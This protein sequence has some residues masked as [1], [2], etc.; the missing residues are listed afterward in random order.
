[1]RVVLNVGLE[2]DSSLQ[3]VISTS[4]VSSSKTIFNFSC[5]KI[6]E[7][8][9][10][11]NLKLQNFKSVLLLQSSSVL[12]AVQALAVVCLPGSSIVHEQNLLEFYI[13]GQCQNEPP[14]GWFKKYKVENK[15]LLFGTVLHIVAIHI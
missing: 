14:I 5:I 13:R 11:F 10:G 8:G 15:T 6:W 9:G 12:F 4:V 3:I 2:K 1:M 7:G